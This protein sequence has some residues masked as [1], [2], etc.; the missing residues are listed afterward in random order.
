M[1]NRV[2]LSFKDPNTG[3]PVEA[4]SDEYLDPNHFR[5][6][7]TVKAFEPC[8]DS[9]HWG[10]TCDCEKELVGCREGPSN[11][12]TAAFAG[13]VQANIFNSAAN[14]TIK[15]TGGVLRS[16]AANSAVS[17]LTMA[18]GTGVTAAAVADFAMQAQTAGSSGS[19]T[20]G[21]TISATTE[22]GVSGTFTIVGTFTNTTAGT[23]AYAEVGITMTAATFVFLVTHDVF[24][25]LSVSV[26]GTL[27]V[28]YTLT[29]Q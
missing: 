3:L 12:C 1:D 14:P 2:R 4:V 6:F 5:I 16:V 18:A 22:T 8:K 24:A 19:I 9:S 29:N 11:L 21:I 23:V 26:N 15:D 20:A 10:H 27:Q 13:L 17:A 25:A 28:T 7:L